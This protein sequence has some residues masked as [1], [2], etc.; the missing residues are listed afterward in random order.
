MIKAILVDD[1][2]L[3]LK[4]LEEMLK[5]HKNV[6]IV[7]SYTNPLDAISELDKTRPQVVFLDIE[8]GQHNG[9]ELADQFLCGQCQIEIIFVTAFSEYAIEAFELNAIDYLLKPVSPARLKNALERISNEPEKELIRQNFYIKSMG[10]FVL[11]DQDDNPIPWR[12]EKS[13]ELFA[14]LWAHQEE[15]ILRSVLVE[16]LFPERDA[17]KANTLFS[18]T[19]YQT[20]KNTTKYFD[21]SFINQINRGYTFDLD[22]E[23]DLG[24]LIKIINQ[25]SY[26]IN[27]FKEIKALYDYSFLE[28]EDYEWK[29]TLENNINSKIKSTIVKIN[30]AIKDTSINDKE[31]VLL[32]LYKLDRFDENTYRDILTFYTRTGQLVKKEK[33]YQD[34][35]AYLKEELGIAI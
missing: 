8:M 16:T 20:R 10:N 33:F 22:I 14:Y 24:N 12:T 21:K 29:S 11:Y 6:E 27:M 2:K 7:G 1:E 28:F 34:H 17:D 19:L 4:V 13:K 32:Y 25:A 9:I 26:D 31:E 35:K 18:T 15:T 23:S 5:K 3:A 30:E